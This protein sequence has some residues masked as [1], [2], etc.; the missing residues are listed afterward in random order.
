MLTVHGA[1]F[2]V[3]TGNL[4]TTEWKVEQNPGAETKCPQ[5]IESMLPFAVQWRACVLENRN[6][7]DIL[8]AH[9]KLLCWKVSGRN[10]PADLGFQWLLSEDEAENQAWSSNS[11][12]LEAVKWGWERIG[13]KHHGALPLGKT[14]AFIWN[15]IIRDDNKANPKYPLLLLGVCVCF[16]HSNRMR[17]WGK[18]FLI[19]IY[20]ANDSSPRFF[21]AYQ[22]SG[23]VLIISPTNSFNP[24]RSFVRLTPILQMR[25]PSQ[26][27]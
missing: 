18:L 26:R 23:S 14:R 19:I 24:H 7:M 16:K 12:F 20:N 3:G 1:V 22:V 21:N 10:V 11:H 15:Q 9:T 5:I 4:I 17:E 25:K 8:C 13:M 2:V 27:S 6:R